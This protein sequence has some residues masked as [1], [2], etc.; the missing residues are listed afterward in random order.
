M[1]VRV[2]KPNRSVA[3]SILAALSVVALAIGSAAPAAP[4]DP[5]LPSAP[6]EPAPLEPA[7]PPSAPPEAIERMDRLARSIIAASPP[8]SD[9]DAAGRVLARLGDL[10]D[11]ADQRILWGCFDAQLGYDPADYRMLALTP[12]VCGA[13]YLS[14]FTFSA[15][16]VRTQQGP[17]TVIEIPA[18]FRAGLS[19]GDYPHPFWHS[20]DQ[21]ESCADTSAV[22]LIFEGERLLAAFHKPTPDEKETAPPREWDEQWSWTEAGASEPRVTQFA[23]LLSRENP[24][25]KTLDQAYRRLT[26]FLESEQCMKCHTPANRMKAEVLAL[27]GYPNQ[28][29]AA[30]ASL[31]EVL[32]KNSMPPADPARG[33]TRGI[34][35]DAVRKAMLA[36][37][38]DFLAEGDAALSYEGVHTIR[39]EEWPDQ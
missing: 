15:P 16:H 27:L 22:L 18:R 23:Y 14:C 32:Q 38:E 24:H 8:A 39:P 28:A 30:R 37:A 33:W 9:R 21:W 20:I 6:G 35:D 2:L 13:L 3:P 29:L 1:H 25:L 26:P 36:A 19:A 7:A 10:I 11:A 4:G 17:F 5:D 34:R 31:V 12:E